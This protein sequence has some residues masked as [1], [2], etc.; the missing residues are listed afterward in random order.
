MQDIEE[1]LSRLTATVT[2]SPVDHAHLSAVLVDLFQYEQT[3]RKETL[4]P[5]QKEALSRARD[6]FNARRDP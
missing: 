2:A 1:L 5:E 6:L 4:T 3:N